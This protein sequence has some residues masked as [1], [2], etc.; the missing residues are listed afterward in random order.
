MRT[1]LQLLLYV[2]LAAAGRL[3]LVTSERAGLLDPGTG[4]YQLAKLM[5]PT[6]LPSCRW[7]LL[8]GTAG[9]SSA[10]F[11]MNST[12]FFMAQQVCNASI[13]STNLLAMHAAGGTVSISDRARPGQSNLTSLAAA[14]EGGAAKALTQMHIAWDFV[15]NIIVTLSATATSGYPRTTHFTRVEVSE[16]DGEVRPLPLVGN[17][18]AVGGCD[19]GCWK[20]VSGPAGISAWRD[21]G[22]W[23]SM[24]HA[25]AARPLE[26]NCGDGCASF[27]V[28]SWWNAFEE[29]GPRRLIGRGVHN[30]SVVSNV[31]ERTGLRT[32][33]WLPA[34]ATQREHGWRGAFFG[35]GVCCELK[36][37]PSEC[38]GHGGQ[39]SI[40][41]YYPGTFGEPRVVMPLA[42]SQAGTDALAFR[43]GLAV[44]HAYPVGGDEGDAGGGALDQQTQFSSRIAAWVGGRLLSFRVTYD[45][46]S[47]FSLPKLTPLAATEEVKLPKGEEPVMMAFT[48]Y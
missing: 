23:R 30:A 4:K 21:Y 11:Y 16:Y 2:T 37:C 34:N 7:D 3:H 31:S 28:E 46:Y 19:H 41:T 44:D 25:G 18:S 22:A 43:M 10:V 20:R 27:V 15:C 38:E 32:M 48:Y 45:D 1:K 47:A 6:V 40:V 14:A 35:L 42:G 13:T 39:I 36:D 17:E 26:S 9:Q 12:L 33:S 24:Q 8:L 5:L 29:Q